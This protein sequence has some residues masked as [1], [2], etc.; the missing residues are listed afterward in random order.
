MLIIK[1]DFSSYVWLF[2]FESSDASSTVDAIM[3]W[4]SSF[5]VVIQWASDQGSHFKNEFVAEF[6]E[7]LRG[8]HGAPFHSAILPVD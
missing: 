4:F 5:G 8:S 7:K 1:N 2:P 3:E 6:N